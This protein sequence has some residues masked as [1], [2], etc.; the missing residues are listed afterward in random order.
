VEEIVETSQWYQER[1]ERLG[2]EFEAAVE[3]Q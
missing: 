1:K 3:E 2:E